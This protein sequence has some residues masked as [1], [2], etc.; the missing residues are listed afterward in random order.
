MPKLIAAFTTQLPKLLAVPHMAQSASYWHCLV[1]DALVFVAASCRVTPQEVT[2]LATLQ[3]TLCNRLNASVTKVSP[4]I[5][6]LSAFAQLF[7]RGS[8][9]G[10]SPEGAVK[11]VACMLQAM[12]T[13]QVALFHVLLQV[14]V[15][16]L[17]DCRSLD[18][19]CGLRTSLTT[20]SY[21]LFACC[22]RARRWTATRA[23]VS[24]GSC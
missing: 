12:T 23:T 11:Q 7:E 19:L 3:Q 15:A 13:L 24:A 9:A 4:H 2:Q 8:L 6:N 22:R 10:T 1:A 17:S 18:A 20:G 16:W 21:S 14:C 5:V